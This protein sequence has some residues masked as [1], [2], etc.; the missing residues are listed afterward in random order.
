MFNKIFAI[1]LLLL[2]LTLNAA[3]YKLSFGVHDLMVQDIKD[4][5]ALGHIK[6]GTSHTFGINTALVIEHTTKSDIELLAKAEFLLDRNKDHLDDHH[7]PLWFKYLIEAN[8]DV[9]QLAEN[10]KTHWL[11]FMDGKQNTAN[12]IERSVRQY[13]GFGW[14]YGNEKFEFSTNA[15]LGFYFIELDDDTPVMRGYDRDELDDG[16]SSAMFELAATY[17]LNSSVAFSLNARHFASTTGLTALENNIDLSVDYHNAFEQNIDL[18]FKI[19]YVKYDFDRFNTREVNVLPWD[20]DTLIQL[21]L[22][23]PF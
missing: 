6:P 22:I 18:N 21:T 5:G 4:D 15:Y 2:P 13:A 7:I 23:K 19:N 16:E 11:F 1:T 14:Q 17:Y 9:S 20:N 12:S 3:T 8:G 10:H